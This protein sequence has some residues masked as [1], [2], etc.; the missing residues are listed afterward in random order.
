MS[1]FASLLARKEIRDN[2]RYKQSEIAQALS[3]SPAT[4]SRW[5]NG[6]D[7]SDSTISTAKKLADWLGCDLHDLIGVGRDSQE[8]R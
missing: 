5:F 1:N 2:R 7:I 6:K 3:M 8:A 4:I